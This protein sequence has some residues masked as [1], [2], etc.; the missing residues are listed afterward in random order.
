MINTW[1]STKSR[2][3]AHDIK[4]NDF[5]LYIAEAKNAWMGDTGDH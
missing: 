4:K 1:L 2:L 5:M 3:L